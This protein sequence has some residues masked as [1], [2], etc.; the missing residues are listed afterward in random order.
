MIYFLSK[1]A[2]E[3]TWRRSLA[4]AYGCH[5]PGVRRELFE[6]VTLLSYEALFSL[7]ELPLGAYVF[8]DLERLSVEETER[9]AL[10]WNA[11]AAAGPAARLF[12]HP[13]ASMRRYELLRHLHREGINHY[14]AQRLAEPF[15][16]R[17]FPVFIRAE[18]SHFEED[19]SP[20]L[21]CQAELEQAGAELLAAGK[22][23]GNKL[24]VEYID[25]RDESG[26]YH[27]FTACMAAGEII[28]MG[29][30][31][32]SHWVVKALGNAPDRQAALRPYLL[33]HGPM[34]KRVFQLARIDY[35]LVDGKIQVFEINTNP[36]IGTAE[37]LLKIARLLDAPPTEARIPSP[38]PRRGKRGEPARLG[39]SFRLSRRLHLF[40]RQAGLLH[41]EP[42]VL[43]A[44][45]FFSR[46][47]KSARRLMV[48]RLRPRG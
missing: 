15:R 5:G 2:H 26:A 9:A 3:Y 28:F 22:S 37:Y 17:R 24:I 42:A 41:C 21:H 30:A 8:A 20:L 16:L 18:D 1:R 7:R 27:Y 31:R 38:P 19:M 14:D 46:W 47:L 39:R 23:R 45:Y 33:A 44:A 6:R 40:L 29:H 13:S 11:L 25:A 34:L 36:T 12:N 32:S 35:A 48:D 4:S 43:R 10:C